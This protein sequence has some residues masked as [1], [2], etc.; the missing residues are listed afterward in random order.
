[1]SPF[2]LSRFV[3]CLFSEWLISVIVNEHCK[4]WLYQRIILK[5]DP[6]FSSSDDLTRPV[7]IHQSSPLWAIGQP[8]IISVLIIFPSF[9]CWGLSIDTIT[10]IIL[11]KENWHCKARIKISAFFFLFLVCFF[12]F[13]KDDVLPPMATSCTAHPKATEPGAVVQPLHVYGLLPA[14][15]PAGEKALHHLC[16]GLSRCPLPHLLQLLGK[17]LSVPLS[18]R[19]AARCGPRPGYSRNLRMKSVTVMWTVDQIFLF[20]STKLNYV[21]LE[22]D[23]AEL[24]KWTDRS[25]FWGGNIRCTFIITREL[26]IKNLNA[27]ANMWEHSVQK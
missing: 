23:S 26:S 17:L 16:I 5:I 11:D 18:W 9:I 10:C 7:T 24:L 27:W 2:T 6:L 22:M 20:F 4:H 1:M 3:D 25:K 13:S 12:F 14:Q 21:W 8:W 19:H 15:L